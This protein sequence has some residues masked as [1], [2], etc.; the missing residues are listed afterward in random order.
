MGAA[1]RQR[2]LDNFTWQYVMEQHVQ[3]WDDLWNAPGEPEP[4]RDVAHPQA[5]PYGRVFGHYTSR[6]LA[7]DTM[8][9]AGRTGDAFYRGKDYP[10]L[11]S[12]MTL[13]IDPE[14]A[15]NLFSRS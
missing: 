7:P 9:K 1:A 3:L 12:G 14:V 10:T 2:V 8:L 11:Y 13:T 5:I 6:T 4:L 15:K